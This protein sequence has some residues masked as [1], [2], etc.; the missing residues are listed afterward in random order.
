M[1]SVVSFA[2]M[3]LPPGDFLTYYV[4]ELRAQGQEVSQELIQALEIRYGLNDPSYTRYFKWITGFV[5]G[6]LGLSLRYNRPVSDLIMER[7][8]FTALIAVLTLIFQWV[9]S[10]PIGIYSAVRQYSVT[11]YIATI[12]GFLGLAI[13][14]FLLALVI[15]YVSYAHFGHSI[16]GLFAPQFVGEPWSVPKLL[17]LASNIWVPIV[18]V[19]TAGT[20]GSIRVLRGQILDELG[21]HYVQ[22]ARAKGLS[23]FIVVWKHMLRVAINPVVSTV[24]WILP[25]IF[26]GDTITGVVL[27]LPTLGPLLLQ[28]LRYQDMYLAG[29]ILM[30][31]TILVVIGTLISDVLLAMVDPRIRYD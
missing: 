15:M 26:A 27:G 13:P 7:V 21:K 4:A 22:T 18:V 31:Q 17:S 9:V 25:E 28:A 14:N 1:I 16:S 10:V 20:A 3:E 11:D 12:F 8:G 24:G 6:D 23:E 5:Q 29:S 2:I 30:V 19:G